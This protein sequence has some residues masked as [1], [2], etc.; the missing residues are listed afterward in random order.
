MQGFRVLVE[1]GFSS[2]ETEVHIV[3]WQ[4][5]K[6]YK[7]KPTDLIFEECCDEGL[8]FKEPAFR[9]SRE[10]GGMLEALYLA[11]APDGTNLDGNFSDGK[12]QAQ[13]KHLEDLRL[14]NQ[15]MMRKLT[16][17]PSDPLS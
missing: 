17:I 8:S 2:D 3:C 6:R 12:I 5:G 14:M 4:N 13:E 10:Q 11:L 9:V 16:H 7:L 1:E 15:A